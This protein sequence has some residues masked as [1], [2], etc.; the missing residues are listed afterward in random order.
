MRNDCFRATSEK[1]NWRSSGKTWR[2]LLPKKN[3]DLIGFNAR[4]AAVG[5]Y[6]KMNY[7]T[8]REA[9]QIKD[10]GE[11]YLMLKKL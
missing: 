9:F 7:K 2:K 10:F 5:F 3:I 8:V 11:H 6:Q 1:R 4:T